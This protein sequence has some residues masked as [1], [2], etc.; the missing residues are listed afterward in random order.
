MAR[1]I[2][3]RGVDDTTHAALCARAE[4]ERL[5]L[6]AYLKR[7]LVRSADEPPTIAELL[8]RADQRRRRG[9]SVDTA[10][11]V[12]AVRALRDEGE[13]AVSAGTDPA[14][15]CL[16]NDRLGT[17]GHESMAS[18]LTRATNRDRAVTHETAIEATRPVRDAGD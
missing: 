1:T 12:A 14:S 15:P 2:R 6:S 17:D 13:E 16:R 8:D 18:W 11:I 9:A 5:S 10:D 4:A 3:I 7:E